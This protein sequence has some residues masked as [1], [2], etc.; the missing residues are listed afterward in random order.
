MYGCLNYNRIS[1]SLAMI[2]KY[3]PCE[4][5]LVEAHNWHTVLH[6]LFQ[7]HIGHHRSGLKAITYQV[8]RPL[9]IK[10]KRQIHQRSVLFQP[11]QISWWQKHCFNKQSHSPPLIISKRLLATCAGGAAAFLF[12]FFFTGVFFFFLTAAFF[13]TL[14]GPAS[15]PTGFF[16]QHKLKTLYC[17]KQLVINMT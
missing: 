1:Q 16:L 2:L 7:G 9:H 4:A 14:D 8:S 13:L 5:K 10:S 3:M 12:I 15:S 17:S 6:I 11:S